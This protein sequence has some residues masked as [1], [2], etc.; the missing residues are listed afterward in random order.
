MTGKESTTSTAGSNGGISLSYRRAHSLKNEAQNELIRMN[1]LNSRLGSFVDIVKLE[2]I[3]SDTL[4]QEVYEQKQEIIRNLDNNMSKYREDLLVTK[5][6]LNEITFSLNSVQVN[7]RSS[8]IKA[9]WFAKLLKFE[10]NNLHQKPSINFILTNN[11]NFSCQINRAFARANLTTSNN[12]LGANIVDGN[13]HSLTSSETNCHSTTSGTGTSENSAAS[14]EDENMHSFSLSTSSN[15]SSSQTSL[16][17][18]LSLSAS[19]SSVSESSEAL[20]NNASP[21]IKICTF[22]FTTLCY[23]KLSC[24]KQ[25]L[26]NRTFLD[27]SGLITFLG[28]PKY[29]Q[30]CDTKSNCPYFNLGLEFIFS[31]I[32]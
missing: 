20:S 23:T 26:K 17:S 31:V 2:T 18:S 15:M 27:H 13:F 32:S 25:R 8:R 11:F 22:L 29:A 6:L 19:S 9:D 21:V 10:L 3:R 5:K 16:A 30:N 14:C 4:K 24:Y 1:N 12:I 28:Y 7:E